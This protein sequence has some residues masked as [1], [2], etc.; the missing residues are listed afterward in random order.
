MEAPTGTVNSPASSRSDHAR[1]G[2][3]APRGIRSARAAHSTSADRRSDPPRRCRSH[4]PS[5]GSSVRG[6][7]DALGGQGGDPAA[8][9]DKP[10]ARPRPRRAR[11]APRSQGSNRRRGHRLL[12]REQRCHAQTANMLAP[13]LASAFRVRR[14]STRRHANGR[15]DAKAR[16]W[17]RVGADEVAPEP[18]R[19]A[20]RA[21]RREAERPR[22]GGGLGLRDGGLE[23]D[24]GIGALVQR[25]AG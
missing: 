22:S 15:G 13:G 11:L 16:A 21:R 24:P 23:L 7:V 12:R 20:A 5:L 4:G 6:V 14:R 19:S 17:A 10:H 2:S 9:D 8:M 3:N 18:T 25:R 1:T